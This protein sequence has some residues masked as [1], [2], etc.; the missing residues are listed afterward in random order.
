MPAY[1]RDGKA[2]YHNVTCQDPTEPTTLW[3]SQEYASSDVPDRFTPCWVAFQRA[4]SSCHGKPIR[5]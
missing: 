1:A 5:R 2:V 4:N 3:T